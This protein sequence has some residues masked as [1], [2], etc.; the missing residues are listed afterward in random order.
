[1][2]LQSVFRVSHD[3]VGIASLACKEDF[4]HSAEASFCHLKSHAMQGFRRSLPALY[5]RLVEPHP[6]ENRRAE[7]RCT[8][9]PVMLWSYLEQY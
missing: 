8:V 7:G 9:P 1:M 6:R 4:A 5:R 3:Q 2:T